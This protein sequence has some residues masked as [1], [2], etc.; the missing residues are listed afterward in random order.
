MSYTYGPSTSVLT[1][2]EPIPS[3]KREEKRGAVYTKPWVVELMLDLAGYTA[4]RDLGG[5]RAVEPA[6]GA[7]GFLVPMVE[8][9][10]RS[11]AE[12]GR[13]IVACSSALAA[14][15]LDPVVVETW[16]AN[17]STVLAAHGVGPM[18]AERL[19]S[20]WVRHADYLL[21]AAHPAQADFVIGNPPYI[22]LEDV[23]AATAA[24]YRGRFRT[25]VGRA[26]V[27]VAF[28]EAALKQLKT[29]G[30]CA[31][32]CADRWMLN[33]YGAELR[34]LVTSGF[35]VETVIELHRADAFENEVSAYPAITVIRRAEQGGA[36]VARAG[37]GVERLG[38]SAIRSVLA[39][40]IG[41]SPTDGTRRVLSAARVGGWF[42]E[43]A[44]WPC[45]LP[46]RLALL[47]RLE[48]E[49]YPL[50]SVGTATKVSIGVATGADDIFI[51][52]DADVVE[53]SRL[54]PLAMASDLAGGR[55]SWSGRYLVN[56]WTE[57]GL[58]DLERHPRLKDYFESHQERLRARH[59]GKKN[60]AAWFRTIDRVDASLTGKT[61]LYIADIKDRLVPVI[62]RGGTYPH[63][64]LYFVQSAGW[65]PEVLGGLLLSDV[66]QFFVECY[67]VRMRGGYL[68]FQAQYLRRIRLPRPHD[69]S[70]SQPAALRAAFNAR[71]RVTVT[72][73]ALSLY[74]IDELPGENS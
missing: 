45:S 59:V 18:D 35:A 31:F 52:S 46:A 74:R 24:A 40:G 49:F 53:A 25:M 21:A 22:R 20:A 29:G 34:R 14:F 71:D 17:V 41:S 4:D 43:D 19:V 28:F 16:R 13:E 44:P 55:L 51:T 69:I 58:V 54:L 23:D 33:Q 32:I 8:R 27:Y 73:I 36:V 30:V 64:N 10:L 66:A 68:R 11:C 9:L 39:Q 48:A 12:H 70:A 67:A 42:E 62:D 65:D 6:V 37:A 38:S 72:A 61:K 2:V 63:H 50:E 15:D 1:T 7:G 60:D 5:A 26:D 56:P 3:T 47:K 57:R